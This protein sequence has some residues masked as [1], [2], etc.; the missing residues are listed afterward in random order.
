ML[1]IFVISAV[2]FKPFNLIFLS[3]L[4]L[5]QSLKFISLM[6]SHRSELNRV[7][8]PNGL[9]FGFGILAFNLIFIFFGL[10]EAA[11]LLAFLYALISAVNRF[12][13]T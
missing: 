2:Y 1:L 5:L 13:D 9:G 6:K 3:V 12:A 10:T 4:I 8:W 7:L 11:V